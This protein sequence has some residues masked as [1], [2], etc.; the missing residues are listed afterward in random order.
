M[1]VRPLAV[2]LAPL[3][4]AAALAAPAVRAGETRESDAAGVHVAVTPGRLDAAVWEFA[5][6]FRSQ[7]PV[8]RDDMMRAASLVVDGQ[9]AAPIAWREVA[10][11][12]AHYRAGLL[13]FVA[14]AWSPH[15]IEVRLQ[16]SGE[17]QVRA[18]RWDMGGWLALQTPP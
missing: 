7:G 8:L 9:A 13:R 6:S 2:V 16:R 17:A 11:R 3:A 10:P 5:V 18:F 1:S 14:P 15:A 4:L 12:E